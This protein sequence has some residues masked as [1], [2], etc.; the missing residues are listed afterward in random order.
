[1]NHYL[2]GLLVLSLTAGIWLAARQSASAEKNAPA[3]IRF[4]RTGGL[5]IDHKNVNAIDS[6]SPQAVARIKQMSVFFAHASVG[7]NMVAGL[8]TLREKL[9]MPCPSITTK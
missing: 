6:A 3:S 5:L 7:T 2:T 8:N 9:G 1:M 4:N